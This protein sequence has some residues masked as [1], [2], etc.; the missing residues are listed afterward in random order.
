MP[1]SGTFAAN[2][3]GT[4]DMDDKALG[5]WLD[6]SGYNVGTL[7]DAL[8]VARKTVSRWVNGVTAVP[9][10]LAGR[11][12][13]LPKPKV[14]RAASVGG[15]TV[16]D[17]PEELAPVDWRGM[18]NDDREALPIGS[19]GWRYKRGTILP[20]GLW[21][22][23]LVRP[24]VTKSG[25]TVTKIRWGSNAVGLPSMVLIGSTEFATTPEH[26]DGLY[27]LPP[28]S[29]RSFTPADG[30]RRDGKEDAEP[31]GGKK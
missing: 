11:L 5:H 7:A 30:H 26:K 1:A 22:E 28:G 2:G 15:V 20:K 16:R 24:E 4:W 23:E 17:L 27:S 13:L 19:V 12:E 3:S 14:A 31:K 18:T 8:G 6:A 9:D 25:A 10:D 21:V 29:F